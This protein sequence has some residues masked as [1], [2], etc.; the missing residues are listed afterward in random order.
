MSEIAFHAI[1]SFVNDLGEFF[2]SENHPLSLYERLLNKTT[3]SHKEAVE[4]HIASFKKFCVDNR[5]SIIT[6]TA[7]FGCNIEYSQKV[8]IDMNA[9]LA[10]NMDKDTRGTIWTHLLTIS[11][12]LDPQSK[13]R[14]MLKSQQTDVIQKVPD[15]TPEGEFLSDVFSKIE[16]VVDPNSTDPNEAISKVMSSGIVSELV[17]SIGSKVS[18]GN[19]DIGKMFESVQNMIGNIAPDASN[20]PQLAQTMSMLSG[21][22]NMMGKK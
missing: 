20:D 12:I 19:L 10:L 17:S 14:D 1:K 18:S 11:A 8:F 9:V 13:A 15:A 16:K 22:M 4:K 5:E 21:M 2:S 6:K 3:I 7:Q